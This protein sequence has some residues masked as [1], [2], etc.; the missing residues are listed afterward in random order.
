MKDAFL[1]DRV[2]EAKCDPFML[3]QKGNNKT[4]VEMEREE[5][6]EVD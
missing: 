5:E 2:R 1:G 4:V 3:I 6:I